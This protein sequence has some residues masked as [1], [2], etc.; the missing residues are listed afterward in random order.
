MTRD[1][2]SGFCLMAAVI[3]SRRI[4]VTAWSKEAARSA[5]A[6]SSSKSASF[7]EG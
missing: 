6:V 3:F 2:V 5:L 4:S 7:D 1:L